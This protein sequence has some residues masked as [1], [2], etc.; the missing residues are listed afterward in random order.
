MEI[1]YPGSVDTIKEFAKG[2][3]ISFEK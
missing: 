1:K 3:H 2:D